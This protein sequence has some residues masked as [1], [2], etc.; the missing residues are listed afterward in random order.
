M[1]APSKDGLQFVKMVYGL[2][3]LAV[4]AFLALY[5]AVKHVKAEDSYGLDLIIGGLLSLSGA[6]G[7]WAFDSSDSK[8]NALDPS[9]KPG[10]STISIATAAPT[11][12]TPAPP[13]E[14]R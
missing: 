10:E 9:L 7:S 2:C 13:Q 3:I 4:L 5:I 12:S 8:H 6:F 11:A 1:T 14:S